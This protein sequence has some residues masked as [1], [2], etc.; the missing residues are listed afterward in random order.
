MIDIKNGKE[1]HEKWRSSIYRRH[2]GVSEYLKREHARIQRK[3]GFGDA[4]AWLANT[5]NRLKIGRSG[6]S[7]DCC[8]TRIKDYA[9]AKAKKTQ[10]QIFFEASEVKRLAISKEKQACHV[11]EFIRDVVETAGVAFPLKSEEDGYSDKERIAAF[12]R[13]C[14]PAWWRRQLRKIASRQLEAVLRDMGAVALNKAKYLSNFSLRRRADQQRRNRRLLESLEAVNDKGQV[15]TLAE[16]SDLSVSNPINRY[17]ELMTRLHGVQEYAKDSDYHGVKYACLFLT[18]SA[19]SKYHAMTFRRWKN[20]KGF[21]VKRNPNY[22]GFTPRECN[23]YLCDVYARIRAEWARR[24]IKP[25]GFRMVEPH[26]D[27]TPHWHLAM[28]F[29]EDKII[30]ASYVFHHYALEEDSDEK[31]AR[32]SRYKIVYIDPDKGCAVAYCCKYISKNITGFN[33]GKDSYD[34]DAIEAALRIEAWKSTWGIRQFDFKNMPSVTVWREARRIKN[35]EVRIYLSPEAEAI[36]EAA[37]DGDWQRYMDLM[38]GVDCALEDRPVRACMIDRDDENKYGEILAVFDGLLFSE[39]GEH[40]ETR[41][42]TWEVRRATFTANT[43]AWSTSL[44]GF[45]E[46]GGNRPILDLYQ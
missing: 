17:N 30:E 9:E 13:V 31:G 38:G 3:T 29:P 42:Y 7:C 5:A 43:E 36:I 11:T 25:F 8:D 40:V 6:L 22:V 18:L 12:A 39:H 16:L 2:P 21:S 37:C 35:S 41:V 28:W 34:G 15:Y 32:E 27:G 45:S 14:D 10:R 24:D 46:R 23:D 19:P 20:K 33:V 4:D 1:E 26:H 44:R